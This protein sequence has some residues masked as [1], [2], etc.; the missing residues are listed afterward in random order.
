MCV[1]NRGSVPPYDASRNNNRTVNVGDTSYADD[2][3]AGHNAKI[4]DQHFRNIEGHAASQP[5]MVVAGNH[6]A[7]A[8]TFF[9]W[10]R[11]CLLLLGK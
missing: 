8:D 1:V 6:E 9:K 2:Y 5:F 7:Y 3:E 11:C 10:W 4:F